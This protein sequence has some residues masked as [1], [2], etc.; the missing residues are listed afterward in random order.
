MEN[1]IVNF[2]DFQ[3]DADIATLYVQ[4]ETEHEGWGA[5][6]DVYA[7]DMTDVLGAI[8]TLTGDD[9]IK[10]FENEERKQYNKGKK[11]WREDDIIFEIK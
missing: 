8:R 2:P 10:P 4:S 6:P 3:I 1:Y 9:E 7:D 11:R 5:T